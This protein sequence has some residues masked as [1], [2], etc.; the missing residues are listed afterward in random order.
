MSSNCLVSPDNTQVKKTTLDALSLQCKLMVQNY[1]I[2]TSQINNGE[3]QEELGQQ[4]RIK[5]T[6]F[7]ALTND[8]KADYA[9]L[10][11]ANIKELSESTKEEKKMLHHSTFKELRDSNLIRI[12]PSNYLHLQIS[13]VFSQLI[14]D[15][16]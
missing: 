13:L 8:V 16:L 4:Q 7:S 1:K 12:I 15:L 5:N 2:I 3:I 6:I 14:C 11:A 9:R 10:K